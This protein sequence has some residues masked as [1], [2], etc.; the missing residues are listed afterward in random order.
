MAGR[1]TSRPRRNSWCPTGVLLLVGLL[2]AACS[3]G[4][5]APSKVTRGGGKPYQINGV[6]YH[7]KDDPNYD[8][9]GLASWYGPGFH[10]RRTA[11]GQRYDM[12][13]PTAAH[14]TLP[15]GTRVQVTNLENGRS[16]SLTVNDRGP[17]VRGRI[18]DVSR[19]A[20]GR[21]GF[22]GKGTARVRVRVEGGTSRVTDAARTPSRSAEPARSREPVP[23]AAE[24]GAAERDVHFQTALDSALQTG[25]VRSETPWRDP[26]SG[27]HGLITP[28]TAPR[29]TSGPYCRNYRRTSVGGQGQ[30]LFVGRACR[31]AEGVWQVKREKPS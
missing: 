15:F 18:I 19:R 8:E 30:S 6:W 10:G 5:E 11:S 25:A 24:P 20:A 28:L 16:V 26:Q 13:A 3:T 21:L 2:L 9:V 31:D 12:N 17:F 23:A 29:S 14:K 4:M 22:R 1:A 7:P 27:R